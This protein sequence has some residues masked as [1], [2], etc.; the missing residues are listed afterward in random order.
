MNHYISYFNTSW[1]SETDGPGKRL[2]LFLQGCPLD[3]A[4]CHS[5]HSQPSESPLLYFD[6]LCLGCQRCEEACPQGVHSFINGEHQIQRDQCTKCGSCLEACPQS[7]EFARGSALALPTRK[8]DVDTLFEKIR[9]QLE[10]L[11]NEGGITFSGGEPL[12][13]S[14]SLTILAKKCKEAGFHTALETSGIVSLKSIEMIEPF[15]DTWLFGMRLVTGTSTFTSDYLEKQTRK[16]LQFITESK[17]A[18]VIVRIPVIPGYTDTNKYLETARR[19]ISEYSLEHIELL[20]HNRES[21]HY[22]DAL[23]SK[24]SIEYNEH[25]AVNNYKLVTEFFNIN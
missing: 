22:Y 16:S 9:P 5:P 21:S 23:N 1:L 20:K 2:V 19:I 8:S 24:A 17:N 13:Q 12:L 7:S 4:W 14:E 10:M 18:S 6:S 15:I 25:E 11:Q 3:C